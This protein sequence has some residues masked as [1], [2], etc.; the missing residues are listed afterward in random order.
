[1][2]LES[3]LCAGQ[4][5]SRSHDSGANRASSPKEGDSRPANRPASQQSLQSMGF[6]FSVSNAGRKG[7]GSR[8]G[9]A[10]HATIQWDLGPVSAAVPLRL[11]TSFSQG[12]LAENEGSASKKKLYLSKAPYL[13]RGK[14][15]V[16]CPG[17]KERQERVNIKLC[18]A[19]VSQSR[20]SH[21]R[22]RRRVSWQEQAFM[23]K[24]SREF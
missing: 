3:A 7:P 24:T 17:G 19:R 6:P 18:G 13:R 21:F 16:R 8:S 4:N 12:S 5:V 10:M 22:Q 14:E 20:Q 15:K 9:R 11:L 2:A 23:F 1:M